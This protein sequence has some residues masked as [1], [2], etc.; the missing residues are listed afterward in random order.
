MKKKNQIILALLSGTVTVTLL[1]YIFFGVR[2]H[3]SFKEVM[4]RSAVN[5]AGM[6]TGVFITYVIIRLFPGEKG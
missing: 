1:N 4:I 3:D 6:V 2:G 5:I